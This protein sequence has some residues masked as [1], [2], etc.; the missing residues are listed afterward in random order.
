MKKVILVTAL[1]AIY[2][3]GG[4]SSGGP[5][6]TV[7][8]LGGPHLIAFQD[9]NLPWVDI[10]GSGSGASGKTTYTL[11]TSGKYGIMVLCTNDGKGKIFHAN[12][13][14]MDKVVLSCRPE[15]FT[16]SG[17]I[18]YSS[19]SSA[20]IFW[21]YSTYNTSGSSYS[22]SVYPEQKP[23]YAIEYDSSSNPVK[24]FKK[25]LNIN[26]NVAQNI[27]FNSGVNVDSSTA[28]FNCSDPDY[29]GFALA[30]WEGTHVPLKSF[31]SSS[32]VAI[33]KFIPDSLVGNGGWLFVYDF[34]GS[35]GIEAIYKTFSSRTCNIKPNQYS[36]SV[37]KSFVGTP[38][39]ISLSW[40]SWNHGV[41]GHTLRFYRFNISYN[42]Y[43]Y[44]WTI[45]LSSGWLGPSS[46][47]TYTFPDISLLGWN[48]SY[49]PNS[50]NVNSVSMTMEATSGSWSDYVSC[51]LNGVC[52]ADNELSWARTTVP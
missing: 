30:F 18:T 14:E 48:S 26:G 34:I 19:G 29:T 17:N 45:D 4:G 42:S 49:I 51:R 16:L 8:V 46:S 52:I 10:S 47:Y 37:T 38:Q 3:C 27:D 15:P 24:V 36:G 44:R 22:F 13:S 39:R 41:T 40:D 35:R 5:T 28:T 9:G 11:N 31:T 33:T 32:T 43:T 7:E 25:A 21:R 50:S 23:I 12:I 1:F 6:L 20:S 2:S